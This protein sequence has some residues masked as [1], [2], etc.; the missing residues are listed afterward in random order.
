VSLLYGDKAV[1]L[2]DD[3]K[4]SSAAV[5]IQAAYNNGRILA[6]S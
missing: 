4:S 3:V 1:L 2:R 5:R 6:N